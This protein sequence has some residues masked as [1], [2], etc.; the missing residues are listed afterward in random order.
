MPKINFFSD[1]INVKNK[2]VIVRLDL[3]VSM[4]ESVIIDD[5][6]IKVSKPLIEDLIQK[7]AIIILISHLGRP[8]GVKIKDLSL[9]PV[10]EYFKNHLNTNIHFFEDDIN[11]QT[12][13]FSKKLNSGDILFLENIRFSKEEE[14]D[15]EKFANKLSKL[16]E[17][18][19]NEAFS[20][21]H[22]KQASLNAITKFLPSFAGPLFEKEINA[23][24]LILKNKKKPVTCI[25]GGSKVSTKISIIKKLLEISENLIVVGAMA[26]NFLKYEGIHVGASLVED[27]MENQIEEILNYAKKKNCKI[28]KPIDCDTSLNMNGNATYKTVDA[29]GSKD[30]ILDIGKKTVELISNVIN[31][32]NTV[33][34]NGPAG[35]FENK[36]FIKGSLEIAKKIAENTKS[37]DLISIVGGGD[38]IASLK[39]TKLQNSFTHLSTAGG[40]FLEYLE[41]RELPAI[42]SL[43]R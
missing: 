19:I 17:V 31:N 16:G 38:T 3:N 41:G 1:K 5:T 21:S 37:K 8:K 40:A 39:N 33:F 29:I 28:I 25:I 27:G 20:C 14:L 32:S 12:I 30:I 11:E 9:K 10:Y 23:L 4:K 42:R 43:K 2:R 22:R 13:D 18:F 35:Y 24:E 6:R 7:G 26:N 34:W 36:N 15:D